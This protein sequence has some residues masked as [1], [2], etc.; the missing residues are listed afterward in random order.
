MGNLL[1]CIKN[2]NKININKINDKQCPH[3]KFIFN[4]KKKKK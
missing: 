4:S 1:T 2:D 3:C